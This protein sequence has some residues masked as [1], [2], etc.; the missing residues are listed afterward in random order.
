MLGGFVNRLRLRVASACDGDGG[1]PLDVCELVK[2]TVH[3]LHH[4][5]ALADGRGDSLDAARARVARSEHSWNAGLEQV[6]AA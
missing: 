5:G 3:E 1:K 2:R 6:W 4:R